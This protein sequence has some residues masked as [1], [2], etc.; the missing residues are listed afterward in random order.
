MSGS[1]TLPLRS[2]TTYR[3]MYELD[4]ATGAVRRRPV[5]LGDVAFG[6]AVRRGGVVYAIY[7]GGTALWFQA[8]ARRWDV[9]RPD[10]RLLSRRLAG[11]RFEFTV[12]VADDVEHVLRYSRKNRLIRMIDPAYDDLDAHVE[13]FFATWADRSSDEEW[14]RQTLEKWS[15]GFT[16]SN[17]DDAL[18]PR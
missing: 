17:D 7:A 12:L 11:N 4:V 14:R 1:P 8:G 2:Y 13:D 9:G 3:V 15:R 10:V 16:R 6:Y 18:R 5:R